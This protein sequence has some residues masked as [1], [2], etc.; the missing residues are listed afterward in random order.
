MC[1][2]LEPVA[3]ALGLSAGTMT[4]FE[5]R[6]VVLVPLVATEALFFENRLVLQVNGERTPVSVMNQNTSFL[7]NCGK[8]EIS[9]L[10]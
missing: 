4:V 1:G 8:I 2:P 3:L 7:L 9:Y 5:D 6:I 10:R